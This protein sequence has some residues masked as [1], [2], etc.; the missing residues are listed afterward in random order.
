M[1]AMVLGNISK[2]DYACTEAINTLA[3]NLIFSGSQYKIVMMTSCV[4]NEG[5]SFV[6]FNLVRT[7]ANMGYRTIMVDADLRKSVFMSRFDVRINGPRDGLTNYL[8]GRCP[9]GNIIY[10]TN[11]PNVHVIPIGK[12]VINSLPLVTSSSFLSLLSK[13]KTNYDFIIVDTPPVGLVIDSAMIATGCDAAILIVS[14]EKTSRR[15]LVECKQQITKSG[16]VVLGAVLNNVSMDTHKS[17]KYYYKSYYSHYGS[18]YYGGDEA[19]EKSLPR[20]RVKTDERSAPPMRTEIGEKRVPDAR[21]TVPRRN[22]SNDR[23]EI[24]RM[25]YR[26]PQAASSTQQATPPMKA[27]VFN[28]TDN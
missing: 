1:R 10:Q 4:A 3:T 14:S 24:E 7:L 28:A 19:T 2:L 26:T 23:E 6:T 22:D 9:V 12:V 11:V 5:K 18:G 13:L 27:Q 8:A 21:P 15:E 25:Q 16:C 20:A 17:R